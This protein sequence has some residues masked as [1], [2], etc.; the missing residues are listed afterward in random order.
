MLQATEKSEK[1]AL[2]VEQLTSE[3]KMLETQ[4]S[5]DE[6][7]LAPVLQLVSERADGVFMMLFL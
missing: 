6:G 7:V 5:R 4:V 2:S 3:K 1:M